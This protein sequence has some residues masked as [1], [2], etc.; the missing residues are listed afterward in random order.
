MSPRPFVKFDRAVSEP[1]DPCEPGSGRSD[2]RRTHSS[3]RRFVPPGKPCRRRARIDP[4]HVLQMLPE[5]SH[6]VNQRVAYL[7]RRG[8]RPGMIS[9]SPDPASASKRA[10]DGARDADGE[11][12]HAARESPARVR[13][14]DQMNVI[15]LD[16]KVNDPEILARGNGQR[17]VH[18][19]ENTC[20]AE[21]TDCLHRAQRN[22]DG[23]RG[24]VYRAPAMRDAGP[25]PGR[26]LPSGTGAATAPRAWGGQEKLN[27]TTS[28]T[29][30][31]R[32]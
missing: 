16:R 11:T 32:R 14:C 30:L 12:T 25:P 27:R 5:I 6:D 29:T 1:A 13:L 3:R 15:V 18:V 28:H 2:G 7:A 26:D 17:A 31:I 24:D 23:L 10:V 20:R 9:V 4:S 19:R 22:V 21:A 8:E